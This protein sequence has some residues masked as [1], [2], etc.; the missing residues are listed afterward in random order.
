MPPQTRQASLSW[1]VQVQVQEREPLQVEQ[2]P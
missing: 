2:Q 1:A